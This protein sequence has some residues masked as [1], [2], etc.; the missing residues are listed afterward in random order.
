MKQ[1][2]TRTLVALAASLMV[3]GMPL[4]LWRP[5][6]INMGQWL[7][8]ETPL[9]Q[10]D[11]IVALGGDRVRQD[12]AIKLLK[13]R[14]ARQV[15]FVGADVRPHDYQCLGVSNEQAIA[16]PGPSYTTYEEAVVTRQVA[17]ERGF[18]SLLIVT[19]PYHL[20]RTSWT[21]EH[22]LEGT[23]VILS[24]YPSRNGAFSMDAWW[25][26][27]IGRKTVLNEYLGLAFYWASA[28]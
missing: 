19:S 7:V 12:E 1:N 27:Y 6:L 10:V 5:L 16:P 20:R 2:R 18:K 25:K 21:F 8:V 14:I 9:R 22:V 13:Q 11:L 17:L 3:I 24:F 4:L 26:N 28:W 15:L 23:G